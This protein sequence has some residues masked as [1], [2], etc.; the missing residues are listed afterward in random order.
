M[1][2]GRNRALILAV[3]LVDKKATNFLVRN[4]DYKTIFH[5][6]LLGLPCQESILSIINILSGVC[7]F[8]PYVQTIAVIH[9]LINKKEI[10]CIY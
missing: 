2:K 5:H 7:A 8:I 1:K 10:Y 4:S 3:G 9:A 6:S